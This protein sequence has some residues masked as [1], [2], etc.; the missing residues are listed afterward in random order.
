M[1]SKLWEVSASATT[2]R[3]IVFTVGHFL[4]DFYVI[5]TITGASPS[6]ATL[7]S[8]VAP[9]LNGIW[10]WLIDRW[11]SQRHADSELKYTLDDLAE[12]W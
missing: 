5:S 1:I 9:A 3:T 10:F 6:E 8:L 4:I 11:W 7:A 12:K 2:I